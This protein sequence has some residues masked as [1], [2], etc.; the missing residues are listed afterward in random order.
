MSERMTDE[1]L[2][3][4]ITKS[5]MLGCSN[6]GCLVRDIH[7]MG[8]NAICQ[9]YS[10]RTDL[11]L[12]QIL[13]IGQEYR[14]AFQTEREHTRKLEA[15]VAEFRAANKGLAKRLTYEDGWTRN[16]ELQQRAEKAEA[17]ITVVALLPNE[18][19][20]NPVD[21]WACAKDLEAKLENK[22]W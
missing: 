7:G 19:R 2:E 3:L 5:A 9:C 12:Q 8:T 14:W 16:D 22:S 6:H 13:Q 18:W 10:H 4:L 20:E 15:E 21:P 1:R 11:E 17:V